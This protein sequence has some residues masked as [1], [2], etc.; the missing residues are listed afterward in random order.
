MITMW[1]DG[2]ASPNPGPGGFAVL[3][4]TGEPLAL[5][6]ARQTSNIKMEAS[7][8]IAAM[9]YASGQPCEI[10]TD[11]EFWINVLTKWA[12]KW[13]KNGW[14][15]KP[16]PKNRD[17]SLNISPEEAESIPSDIKNLDLVKK[18][19]SLYQ[20]GNTAL[21]FTRGHVGTKLNEAADKWANKARNE[22]INEIK[23]GVS[24]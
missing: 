14:H 15:K 2:S 9:E 17:G 1:T 22:H 18:A 13:E 21:I 20:A 4:S 12:P 8:L 19:Y 6:S 7:A 5:G 3:S 24:L 23:E 16:L 10:Y 11:S